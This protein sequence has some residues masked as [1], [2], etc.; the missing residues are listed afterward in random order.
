MRKIAQ[1]MKL[2]GD[3]T[4]L[5][6]IGLLLEQKLYVCEIQW[7]LDTS[8]SRISHQLR[9]LKDAGLVI[10]ERQGKMISYRWN[11]HQNI[12]GMKEF[13]RLMSL[14]LSNSEQIEKDRKRLKKYLKERP[15]IPTC[16]SVQG[17]ENKK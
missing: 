14:W 11:E 9:I 15:K 13:K 6:I 17:E 16:P 10:E 7:I 4:R 8:Q 3:E 12:P 1:I 5:R 2:L